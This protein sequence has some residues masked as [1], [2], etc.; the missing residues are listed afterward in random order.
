MASGVGVRQFLDLAVVV[1]NGPEL[2]WKWIEVTLEKLGL[3]RYAHACFSLIEKWFGV[4]APVD[5]ERLDENTVEVVTEKI[6][7]NGVFG[8]ADEDNIDNRARNAI[9][10]KSGSTIKNRMSF[11]ISNLFPN[12]M[13]MKEYPGCEFLIGRR[14]MLPLAWLKRFW[15]IATSKDNSARINTVKSTFI[16]EEELEGRRELLTKMG[17]ME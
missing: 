11:L 2:D 9:M 10:L 5:Y 17:M 12:Y 14:Y 16:Q 4:T 15:L 13:C 1:K 7:G 3:T 8:F 6:L